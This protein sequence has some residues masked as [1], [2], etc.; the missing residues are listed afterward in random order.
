MAQL[1]SKRAV[2]V[3]Y[4]ARKTGY[5]ETTIYHW[6]RAGYLPTP[7]PPHKNTRKGR[8]VWAKGVIDTWLNTKFDL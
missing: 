3:D 7:N 1:T 6:K 4:I 8:T 5:S 2:G